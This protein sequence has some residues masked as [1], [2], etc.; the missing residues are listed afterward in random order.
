MQKYGDS[1][2]C[3]NCADIR[4]GYQEAMQNHAAQCSTL[5][6][7]AMWKSTIPNKLQEIN[8][9][10]ERSLNMNETENLK[11]TDPGIRAKVLGKRSHRAR[12]WNNTFE[13]FAGKTF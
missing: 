3:R 10:Q 1:G 4:P 6:D 5:F 7:V 2:T 8:A 9:H 11:N 13:T 12:A